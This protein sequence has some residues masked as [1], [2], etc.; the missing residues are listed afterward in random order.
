VGA[1]EKSRGDASIKFEP[2]VLHVQCY[3]LEHARTMVYGIS[4][5]NRPINLA[6]FV[7]T[8]LTFYE[9]F[10]INMYSLNCQSMHLVTSKMCKWTCSCV[11]CVG[12][13][14]FKKKWNSVC[15][16]LCSTKSRSRLALET[17]AS[18]LENVGRLLWWVW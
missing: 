15:L 10:I 9:F 1:L 3:T 14:L 13:E 7:S 11:T 18:R 6:N 5:T 12:D 8:L 2:F 16:I 4:E 17:L